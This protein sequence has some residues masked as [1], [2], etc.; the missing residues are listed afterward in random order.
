MGD[1]EHIKRCQ[2]EGYSLRVVRVPLRS[3]NELLHGLT[4]KVDFVSLDVEGMELEVL[5]GFD[6]E[7]WHPDVMLV[8]SNNVCAGAGVREYLAPFGLRPAT[9]DI[10]DPE[11]ILPRS[12]KP[13]T[14][15]E[16]EK[17][18]RERGDEFKKHLT[19]HSDGDWP[20]S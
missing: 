4:E 1:E 17:F 11:G 12:E 8:E 2:R 3:L 9:I 16:M 7:K 14:L 5:Q 18:I 15:S 6:I 10:K 20:S 19:F 13:G